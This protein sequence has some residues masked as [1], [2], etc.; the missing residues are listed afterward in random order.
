[1]AEEKRLTKGDL[2]RV[3]AVW[4]CFLHGMYNYERMQGV[5]F[6]HAMVPV[7][8]RL[9]KTKEEISAAL[10]RHLVFF[11]TNTTTGTIAAGIA[12][13]M[14]EQRANGAPLDDESINA[15]KTSLMGPLA[16]LGDS[17]FQGMLFP[18]LLALG[19]GLGREGSVM[20]PILYTVL[21]LGISYPLHYWW[22]MAAF[23]QGRPLLRNLTEGGLLQ[24]ATEGASMVGLLAAGTLTARYVRFVTPVKIQLAGAPPVSIQADVFD[25]IMPNLLPLLLVLGCWAL[26]R[27]GV[28][29]PRIVG[30]VFIG[31]IVLGYLKILG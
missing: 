20:G 29:T 19:I 23:Q 27:R 26:M 15:V 8:K 25:K 7:I 14:E 30:I 11:N 16:G 10:K 28:R 24:R 1:V 21:V 18:I 6:A 2:I 3:W 9:Y 17:I 5:G 12:A 4:T 22:F 31:G 13:A